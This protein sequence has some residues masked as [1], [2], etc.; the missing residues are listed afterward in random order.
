MATEVMS[1]EVVVKEAAFEE[2]TM[3]T[4]AQIIVKCREWNKL[5]IPTTPVSGKKFTFKCQVW[6]YVDSPDPRKCTRC[7]VECNVGDDNVLARD[8]DDWKSASIVRKTEATK[9]YK[10]FWPVVT[11]ATITVKFE[12]S[13][14]ETILGRSEVK[15]DGLLCSYAGA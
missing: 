9:T 13:T 6:G 4:E 14:K 15:Q 12:G 11:E 8:G 3:L 2:T 5:A 10:G 7:G 1:S